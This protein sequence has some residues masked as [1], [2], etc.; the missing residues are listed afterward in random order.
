MGFSDILDFIIISVPEQFLMALFAWVLLGRTERVKLRN[1]FFVGLLS[2]GIFFATQ[3]AKIP[4]VWLPMIQ[5]LGFG[6]LIY[7]GF[8]LNIIEA[9]LGC[10]I[11]LV[12]FTL[13]QGTTI[14][15]V[16]IFTDVSQIDIS[17]VLPIRIFVSFSEF[18]IIGLIL[19][20]I[21][22]KNIDIYYL[23]GSKLDKS[24][25]SRLGFLVL[26]LLFAFLILVII[27]T[28]FITNSE[29]FKSFTDK[30]LIISSFIITIAFTAL[31]V[32][33]VFKLGEVIKKE[34]EVKRRMDGIEFI[35]NIDYLC[36]LIDEKQYSELKRI[37]KSIKNDIEMGMIQSEQ[38][39]NREVVSDDNR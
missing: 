39:D 9:L 13:V 31:L 21:Y 29:V 15:L 38:R 33:S 2:A 20:V 26:Q 24:Q 22:R 36:S 30:L 28:M 25:R 10:L 6:L 7:L 16:S 8:K 37:L 35:Q 11:T 12:F 1:V 14:G 5:A 17:S 18:I 19:F 3:E 4:S 34:E 32:R 27:Y 23:K